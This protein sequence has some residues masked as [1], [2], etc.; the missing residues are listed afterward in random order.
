LHARAAG[1]S[2]V[3]STY[4]RVLQ[5]QL[6][7]KDLAFLAELVPGLT[8][9]V[10]KGRGNYLSL[11]RL[12]EELVDALE[13]DRL[14]PV[15]AWTLG[16]LASFAL[17]S[18]D[19]DLEPLRPAISGIEDALNARGEG[20]T[21][22]NTMRASAEGGRTEKLPGGR[23]DFYATARA[24]AMRADVVVLNHSLLLT[25]AVMAGDQL[26]DLFSPFVVCDEAHNRED[27]ATSVLTYEVSEE[28]VR[29]LLR[30]VYDRPR[31]AGLLASAR[32]AGLP[33]SDEALKAAA[34][35]VVKAETHVDNLS[36]RLRS[37]VEAHTVASREELARYGAAVEI[38][39]TVL[40]G[41]G[42]PSLRESAMAL[43]EV[44]GHL[45]SALEETARSC[46]EHALTDKGSRWAARA[47]RLAR[48]L[49]FDFFELEKTFRWFWTFTEATSYVRVI[50]IEAEVDRRAPWK[51]DGVPIDV[52]ALLQTGFR[53]AFATQGRPWRSHSPRQAATWR[54]LSS[55]RLTIVA[56]SDYRLRV[57]PRHV[58][59]HLLAVLKAV[60]GFDS[61]RGNQLKIIQAVMTG[62]DVLALLP[63]GAGKSLT[64]Q[65]PALLRPGLTVVV[66]PLVALIRDQ[67]QKLRHEA[68]VRFV[69]CLIS[70][71]TAMDQE[72]ALADAK[73]GRLRLL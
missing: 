13:E 29:R 32:K 16:T 14:A 23:R 21:L 36:Q 53:P 37:F 73:N 72:E 51:I 4:T 27:A 11:A 61:F 26:P 20:W 71:M 43:L 62:N 15:R 44:L 33:A 22:V 10:L 24:N 41:P 2:V 50:E 55:G 52:S 46:S 17:T 56:G 28:T 68:E 34:A 18:P 64:F 12:R 69:N 40:Q 39:P 8:S 38:R 65:L 30:A 49:A 35:A 1:K 19:G 54:H 66:S 57:G 5:T 70:G 48:S 47:I 60:W 9:A 67:I 59:T 63:T 7:E 31:R 58:P 45:R 6:L 25:Q 3:V 42:G